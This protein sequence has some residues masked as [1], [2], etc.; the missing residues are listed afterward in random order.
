MRG[1]ALWRSASDPRTEVPPK[2]ILP[3]RYRRK[4]PYI[5]SDGEIEELIQ[6]ARRLPPSTALKGCTY[7]TMF[8][9]LSVTGMRVSEVLALDREDVMLQEGI[10]RIRHTKFDKRYGFSRRV[11]D[12]EKRLGLSAGA[13]AAVWARRRADWGLA[14]PVSGGIRRTVG[15]A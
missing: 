4:P 14:T 2:G 11:A 5:Y 9:L 3:G 1:F 13:V 6:A 15:V 7:A 8:A 12:G 10:I